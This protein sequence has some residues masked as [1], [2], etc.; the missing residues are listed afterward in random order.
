MELPAR[1]PGHRGR[2]EAARAQRQGAGRWREDVRH[3]LARGRPARS[4]GL[5]VT[6]RALRSAARLARG[7]G[8]GAFPGR[9][10]PR[11]GCPAPGPSASPPPAR[12]CCFCLPPGSWM[13]SAGPV[14][15]VLLILTALKHPRNRGV[16]G[17]LVDPD[18]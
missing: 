16:Y 9:R 11:G 1:P 12:S 15:V 10:A 5:C 3:A 4:R 8:P 7:L 18:L 17:G 13:E 6:R 2:G 14:P